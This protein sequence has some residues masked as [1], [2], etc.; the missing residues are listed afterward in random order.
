MMI[1]KAEQIMGDFGRLSLGGKPIST[2]WMWIDTPRTDMAY[3][4]W[5]EM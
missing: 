1:R 2:W 5:W 4:T 3:M